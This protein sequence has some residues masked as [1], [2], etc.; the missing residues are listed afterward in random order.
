MKLLFDLFPVLLFFVAYKMYG[1]YVATAV[2]IAA[3]FIQVG[4]YWLKHRRWE[5]MHLVSLGLITV[6]GGAT[7]LLQD[8]VFI[9]WKPTI[10]NWAF[11]AVFIGSQFIGRQPIIQR[12]MSHAVTVPDF[13]WM[14]LNFY[15]ALF[16]IVSGVANLYVAYNFP[17]E[18]WV[19]FKLFGLM[20]MTF[21][22]IIGQAFYLGRHMAETAEEEG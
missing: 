15:W 11:A 5:K 6:F 3:S 8:P 21:A 1:I 14:R 12:L 19:Q 17:E 16:F 7:L 10:L 18:T 9:Q 22:F 13:V 2:A 20:G 4:G